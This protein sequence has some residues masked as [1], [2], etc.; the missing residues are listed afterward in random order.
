MNDCAEY[1]ELISAYADGEL[2]EFDK[3]RCEAH[4]SGCERCSA[5]LGL[6]REIPAALQEA[7]VLAPDALCD[8][9]MGRISEG[10]AALTETETD[11]DA[12]TNTEA[13]TDTEA[14]IK[15]KRRKTVRAVFLRYVPVAA[16]L[17]L[18][19]ATL[20]RFSNLGC[21]SSVPAS[22][23]GSSSM[24]NMSAPE[25]A[26]SVMQDFSLDAGSGIPAL[27]GG[28][29]MSAAGTYGN[30]SDDAS[31]AAA[32]GALLA[33]QAPNDASVAADTAGSPNSAPMDMG[34]ELP[35]SVNMPTEAPA[36]M[37]ASTEASA[38]VDAPTEAVPPVNAPPEASAIVDA[39]EETSAPVN[40][41]EEMPAPWSSPQLTAPDMPSTPQSPGSATAPGNDAAQGQSDGAPVAAPIYAIIEITGAPWDALGGGS[42]DIA[43]DT[44]ASI[45]IPR[46]LAI[47]LIAYLDGKDGVKIT[48]VDEAGAYAVVVYT[49][50]G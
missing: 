31:R 15:V 47:Q 5:L 7:G 18:L 4:L 8:G 42:Q 45:Q 30:H 50:G 14:D 43:G 35:A 1:F 41:Q 34:A 29:G 17:A 27:A 40:T 9:V 48:L 38:P 12:N 44:E 39:Q 32:G 24:N 21:S 36:P 20:P 2:S 16:C 26:P 10:N 49:P 46:D 11:A 6:Y 13:E 33:P 23:G 28:E 37:N 19:L 22:V 3:Q 25:A